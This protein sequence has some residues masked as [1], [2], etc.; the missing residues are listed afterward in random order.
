[1]ASKFENRPGEPFDGEIV[2]PGIQT[3]DKIVGQENV[4]ARLKEFGEFF[5]SRGSTPGHIL[6]I[7]EEGMGKATIANVFANQT[8]RSFQK[9]DA[10]DLEIKGDFT[11]I[12][13]N[14]HQNQVLLLSGIQLLRQNM[15]SV[16]RGLLRDSRLTITVGQGP[17]ERRHTIDIR[18]FTLIATCPTKADCPLELLGEF[19][20]I[21][22]LEPYSKVALQVIAASIAKKARISL[23][24]GAAEL[25]A[26]C[27]DARPGHL[28][29]IL[30]R[31]IRAI[32]GN[33][34]TTEDA[35][36]AF[37]AFGI[38]VPRDLPADGVGDLTDL[39]GVDFEKLIVSLLA[40]MG[41]QAEMTKASGDGGIDIEATLDKPIVG[42]RYSFQC[43]RFAPDNL[44]G[45]PTLRDFFGAVT[46]DRAVKGVFITTS[47]FTVQAREFGQKAGL[48]LISLPQLRKLLNELGLGNLQSG[49][50]T[51]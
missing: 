27:C 9:V 2:E 1:M 17:R 16:L 20:L 29:S 46:A 28:E 14:L 37:R 50:A 3:Y 4:V 39:S 45:A 47:D 30:Q 15:V 40:R 19:T 31:L 6:L 26:S 7:G 43:K 35:Q 11:A 51:T 42:G 23:D 36:Q 49:T 33:A 25:I 48:E 13:T 34:I 38:S 24:A 21:L 8:L 44:V 10:G 32:N 41:F 5:T 18:P 12:I 22:S